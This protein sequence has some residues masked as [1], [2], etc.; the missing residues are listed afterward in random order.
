MT[1]IHWKT[2]LEHLYRISGTLTQLDG[3]YDLNYLVHADD[4]QTFILKVMRI[5]ATS[6]FID[7][8]CKA[9]Q[10]IKSK[11]KEA[12]VPSLIRNL[13]NDAFCTT[14]DE[15][16]TERVIWVLQH[17]EG[18]NYASYKP[19]SETLI[20]QLGEYL[21]QIDDALHSFSHDELARSFKWNLPESL[22]IKQHIALI[23]QPHRKQLVT[24]TI[25]TFKAILPQLNHLPQ[26]AIH[27]DLNDCNILV[28]H[29]ETGSSFISGLI[30]L[31]DIAHA[32][33]VCDLAICAAYI[34]L[35]HPNP[36]RALEALVS[37]Y[38]QAH[39]LSAKET[40]LVFPL[41]KTR[42]AVSVVNST[43]MAIENPDDPYVVISQEPAWR[44]LERADQLAELINIRLRV[45]CGLPI[46]DSAA[47]VTTFLSQ[48]RGSF[49]PIMGP[50]IKQ[51]KLGQLSV[52]ECAIP[53][54]PFNLSSEEALK[55]NNEVGLGDEWIGKY[56]E[57]RLVYTSN[58]F[59]NGCH[60]T[61][62]RRTVHIAVDIFAE[63]G[64]TLCAPLDGVVK[65]VENRNSHLDYGG[66]VIL[67]HTTTIIGDVRGIGLFIGVELVKDRASKEPATAI[68]NYVLNRLQEHRI[69]VGTEGPF[70]NVLKIRPPLTIEAEDV[71]F[72]IETLNLVLVESFVR[73]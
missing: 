44:F 47:D 20:S 51:V 28:N 10:H 63:E 34:V 37:G 61:S 16:N 58:V 18:Q 59:R 9:Y 33:R 57:P 12:P 67:R 52:K 41:L 24:Q 7:M 60:K 66:V 30:D 6:G 71:S 31:G 40:D 35:D 38:H 73:Q 56:A 70:G 2:Q 55:L 54:N 14:L 69:L 65:I 29:D 27:N 23:D 3:E 48:Q 25:E 62:N 15:H 46:S 19:H 53:Q 4:G 5:G 26:V 17:L 1:I 42:L 72:I 50:D 13:H 43:M 68:A 21:G 32:P 36:E 49:Y 8:Q 45:A 39:P 64:H 11:A 22:W